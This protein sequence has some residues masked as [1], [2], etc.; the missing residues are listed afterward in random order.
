MHYSKVLNGCHFY[1]PEIRKGW[2]SRDYHLSK[3]IGPSM[4]WWGLSPWND[5]DWSATIHRVVVWS[6][7]A[8]GL[9]NWLFFRKSHF[10]F[11]ELKVLIYWNS[12]RLLHELLFLFLQMKSLHKHRKMPL[13]VSFSCNFLILLYFLC[14]CMYLHPFRASSTQTDSD[15]TQT[16]SDTTAIEYGSLLYHHSYFLLFS[17]LLELKK[18]KTLPNHTYVTIISVLNGIWYVDFIC[19]CTEYEIIYIYYIIFFEW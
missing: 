5:G 1:F 17:F 18:K 6:P 8:C 15:R 19:S 11:Q 7:L 16:D 4:K 9:L 2:L 14:M 3:V 12:P 13:P 10:I